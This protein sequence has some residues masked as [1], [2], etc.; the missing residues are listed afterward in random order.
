M[1]P[2]N[3]TITKLLLITSLTLILP[4]CGEDEKPNDSLS[5]SI[6]KDVNTGTLSVAFVDALKGAGISAL[7][8]VF[9]L[10]KA[11]V[12]TLGGLLSFINTDEAITKAKSVFSVS[13]ILFD[14]VSVTDFIPDFD[15]SDLNF[16]ENIDLGIG[17]TNLTVEFE[18]QEGNFITKTF[19]VASD[20]LLGKSSEA[21]TE[22]ESL[23]DTLINAI[24]DAGLFLKDG[25][26]SLKDSAVDTYGELL[27]FINTDKAGEKEESTFEVSSLSFNG[28][29]IR[30][31]VP[32]FNLSSFYDTAL[33]AGD[34][35]LTVEF[36]DEKGNT[37]TQAFGVASDF[38]SDLNL[39]L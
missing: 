11:T 39:G 35:N 21:G 26:F 23:T 36:T 15:L 33:S 20:F 5:E 28:D 24:T 10:E 1:I 7:G 13:G 18:D 38:I 14:N 25:I 32:D 34:E 19:A 22:N 37:I 6:L 30:D 9:S 17:D 3:K 29:S 16:L 31:L 8:A 2:K 12:D 4:S 27:T